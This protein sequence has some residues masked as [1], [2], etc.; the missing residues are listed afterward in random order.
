MLKNKQTAKDFLSNYG[1]FNQYNI[2]TVILF[3]GICTFQHSKVNNY[4]RK[5]KM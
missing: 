4:G 5:Q 1:T 2:F 3:K